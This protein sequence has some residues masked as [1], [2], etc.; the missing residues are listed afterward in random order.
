MRLQE[1]QKEQEQEVITNLCSIPRMPEDLLPHTVYVEEEGEDEEHY[2]MPVYTAYEL[3]NIRKDGS[4]TLY[5]AVSGERFSG[6]H[7]YEINIDWLI[8]VWERYLELCLEQEI[9]KDNAITFLKRHT[10]RP[11]KEIRKFVDS[12]WDKCLAYTDNLKR[13]LGVEDKETWIFSFPIDR[14]ERDAPLNEIVADYERNP[15]TQVEK[16]TP[17]EFTAKINDEMFNDQD[18]WVRTVELPKQ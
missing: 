13:F 14:F 15:K 7:L 12:D 9:W 3:E 1:K 16:M 11:V 2:G 17:L 18:Y 6:R 5:N 10:D 4:C 8:T